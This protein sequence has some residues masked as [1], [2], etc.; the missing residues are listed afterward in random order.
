MAC[1]VKDGLWTKL[2]DVII[3]LL[4]MT[5]LIQCFCDWRVPYFPVYYPQ[6]GQ[7]FIMDVVVLN[8][9]AIW[10]KDGRQLAIEKCDKDG[11]PNYTQPICESSG[12]ASLN[13]T[14]TTLED[15]GKYILEVFCSERRGIQDTRIDTG[16]KRM[17]SFEI[18]IRDRPLVLIDCK[19]M[20]VKEGDNVTC[21][22]KTTSGYPSAEVRWTRTQPVQ[23]NSALNN[24]TGV[25]RLENISRN[26]SGTYTCFAESQKFVNTTSFNLKVVPKNVTSKV[27]IKYFQ[28]FQRA[29]DCKFVIICKAKGIPE[30][31]YTI[32]HNGIPEFENVYNI[33][34]RKI[35]SM[36]Q[37]ECLAKN[38]VSFDRRLLFLNESFLTKPCLDKENVVCNTEMKWT[39]RIIAGGCPFLAGVLVCCV[40][41]RCCKKSK[42]ND[43]DKNDDEQ[44]DDVCPRRAQESLASGGENVAMRLHYTSGSPGNESERD[45]AEYD[46]PESGNSNEHEY[47][48]GSN[49]TEFIVSYK[50]EEKKYQNI[51]F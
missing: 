17:S 48:N 2:V 37:Y 5:S 23:E 21:V 15:S 45:S 9:T 4:Q 14:N 22:C 18:I 28:V 43:C 49:Y 29:G 11:D 42:K 31:R 44:Y 13:F 8:R 34:R 12:I 40:L 1:S 32:I 51:S 7:S 3:M 20:M 30:P 16:I 35:S 38:G 36:G 27:K 26:Q 41:T 33:D 10:R 25:L 19:D 6:P 47:Y 24:L 46:I 39:F 50:N